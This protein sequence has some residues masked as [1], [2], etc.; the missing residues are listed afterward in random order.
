MRL[1][2]PGG[3][4]LDA[5][6]VRRW[7]AGKGSKTMENSGQRAIHVLPGEGQ[8]RW[9]AGDLVTFKIGGED[10]QGMFALAEEVTPHK[11]GL[12]LTCTPAKTRPSTCWRGS[13]SSWSARAPSRRAL[14]R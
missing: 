3:I 11:V 6:Q 14:G 1:T 9:V 8:M 5:R 10:A 12:L 7:E 13:W 4:M 2:S